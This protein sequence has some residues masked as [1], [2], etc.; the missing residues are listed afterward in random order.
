MS[1]LWSIGFFCGDINLFCRERVCDASLDL[2]TAHRM[3]GDIGLF[4]GDIRLFC[5][6]LETAHRMGILQS[7]HAPPV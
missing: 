7:N 4:C 6:D 5:G 2:E 1:L 3:G